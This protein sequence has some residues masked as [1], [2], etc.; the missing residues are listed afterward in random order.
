MS[1][2][3]KFCHTPLLLFSLFAIYIVQL[4]GNTVSGHLITYTLLELGWIP[5]WLQNCLN[6][7]C[8]HQGGLSLAMLMAMNRKWQ[9]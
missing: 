2:S 1:C 8:H 6:S 7:L 9:I 3:R 5:F 4:M